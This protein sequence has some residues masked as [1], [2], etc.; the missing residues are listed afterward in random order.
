MTLSQIREYTDKM[1][2]HSLQQLDALSGLTISVREQ[3]DHCEICQGR[4]LVRKSY[5]HR[6][7]T[8]AHG[9]FDVTETFWVCANGCLHPCSRQV[10][11]RPASFRSSSKTHATRPGQ[12][13]LRSKRLSF[14]RDHTL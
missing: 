11:Q 12:A 9:M 2:G 4:I 1:H 10:I 5:T 6:G 7:R 3:P 14:Q 13:L 8:L